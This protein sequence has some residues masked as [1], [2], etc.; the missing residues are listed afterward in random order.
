M[1]T[2][3]VRGQRFLLLALF[4]VGALASLLVGQTTGTSPAVKVIGTFERMKDIDLERGIWRSN[5]GGGISRQHATDGQQSLWTGFSRAGAVL[6]STA[7]GLPNDWSGYERL[8]LDAYCEGA[9]IILTITVVDQAGNRYSVPHYYLRAGANIIE[10]NL[11]GA[12]HVDPAVD[13][14]HVTSLALV[15]ERAPEG[16]NTTFVDNIRLTRGVANLIP[17]EL[18]KLPEIPVVAGNLVTN[19]GFEYGLT[20]W[21]FWGNFDWGEYR[22]GTASTGDA[23]TGSSA[24]TITSVGFK[25]GR[26]GLASDRIW[27]PY[28]GGYRV[29]LFVKGTAGAVFRLGAANANLVK[30]TPDVTV[31]PEWQELTYDISL[32]DEREPIRLWLYNVGMGTLFLDDVS[33]TAVG[34]APQAASETTLQGKADVRLTGSVLYVN[35]EPFF[36][37]G[38]L[39]CDEP[40]TD[41]ANSPLN[42]ALAPVLIGNPRPFLDRCAKAG[43]FAIANASESVSAHV[44]TSI[45]ATLKLVENHPA[46]IGYLLADEPD[47]AAHPV[48]PGEVRLARQTLQKLGHSLPTLLRLEGRSP[49]SVYQ[50]GDLSDVLLVSASAVRAAR[51]FDLTDVTRPIDAAKAVVRG[52]AP[53]WVVLDVRGAGP[54]EAEPA[55]LSAMAYAAVSH[56]ADGL[57]WEPFSYIKDRPAFWEAIRATADELRQLTPALTSPVVRVITK[58]V[59]KTGGTPMHGTSRRHQDQLYLI[60][61]NVT[62]EAQPGTTFTL[63]GVPSSAPVEVLFEN[64]TLTLDGGVLTD[65]FAPYAR[66]VY[67]LQAPAETPA[68]PTPEAPAPTSAPGS[69]S[70]PPAAAAP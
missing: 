61:V 18:A 32:I 11:A 26:G 9:S 40:D 50:F 25:P 6:A 17:T 55:E 52:K 45:S 46:V 10:V 68:I 29:K 1:V 3:A 19:S 22:A 47:G 24:A 64:R 44:P 2:P 12:A 20:G 5:T 49:S 56:G 66:H 33:L 57:L 59:T 13:L 65:D 4:L 23:H 8:C 48:P 36:A 14:T 62:Q 7:A 67:R 31:T 53:V 51:P 35:G 58:T 43:V 39:G 41:L 21:Q 63:A 69:A 60:I 54:V 27:P 30:E 37:R 16:Q 38:I 34:S 70:T 28:G 42:P 15:T